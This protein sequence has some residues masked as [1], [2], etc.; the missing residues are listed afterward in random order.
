MTMID[1]A[2]GWFEIVNIPKF[3]LEEVT[4]GN[5]E[6][7]DQSSSRV[8]YMFNNTWICRYPRPRKVVFNNVYGFKRDFTPLLK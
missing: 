5:G 8:R 4:L 3:D 7:I 1:L 2:I 6:Y